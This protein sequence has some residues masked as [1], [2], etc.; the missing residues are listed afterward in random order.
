[1]WER[2]KIERVRETAKREEKRIIRGKEREWEIQCKWERG[3]WERQKEKR[4][5]ERVKMWESK[6]WERHIENA[7]LREIFERKRQRMCVGD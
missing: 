3:E 7:M 1:M 2:E 6:E 5:R 4:E